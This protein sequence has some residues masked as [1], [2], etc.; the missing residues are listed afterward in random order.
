MWLRLI[1]A[2]K[3]RLSKWKTYSHFGIRYLTICILADVFSK[4]G[5][6]RVSEKYFK[7][8]DKFLIEYL[9]QT[10]QPVVNK[11]E[12]CREKGCYI[13]NMP[14]W[15]CW[16][17]G[18]KTAPPI[19]QQCIKSIWHKSGNHQ[20]IFIDKNNYMKYLDIPNYILQKMQCGKMGLA[21]FADY[22]RVSLL[23]RYGGLWLD[24][25]IYCSQNVPNDFFNYP[26]FT[27]KSNYT[28]SRYISKHQWVTFC[29]GGWKGN[30]FYSFMKEA[31]EIYWKEN[32]YAI[33]Y[34]F[35][36]Y[37][38]FIAKEK[39]PYINELMDNVPENTPHRDDLQAAMNKRLPADKFNE[40]IKNDTELYKLSWRETYSDSSIDGRDSI[41]KHFI[42][43]D[44]DDEKKDY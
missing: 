23:D 20:V 25:T 42:M 41:Y 2:I 13:E 14:I 28:E 44:E 38:I 39:N 17:T 26:F 8:K 12:H 3:R 29:L 5:M 27:L 4:I 18:L 19:V 43:M 34:L 33:D 22:I 6:K 30:Q 24:G 15:V 1:K 10:I 35:F 40:V 31:F 16:W 21:H 11:F 36:D 7:K 9:S 37:L 32:E